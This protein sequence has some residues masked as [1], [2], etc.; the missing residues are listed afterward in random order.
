MPNERRTLVVIGKIKILQ[1]SHIIYYYIIYACSAILHLRSFTQ[2]QYIV[3]LLAHEIHTCN[4][5]Q[6]WCQGSVLQLKTGE[7]TFGADQPLAFSRNLTMKSQWK[8][9]KSTN[10]FQTDFIMSRH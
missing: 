4:V 9:K 1:N 5:H 2:I 10:S 6:G 7:S 8:A 3:E